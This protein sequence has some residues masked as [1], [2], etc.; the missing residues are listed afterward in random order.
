MEKS[1]KSQY[2]KR[3]LAMAMS[4]V[5]AFSVIFIFD[6]PLVTEAASAE[7]NDSMAWEV[8]TIVNQE[9]AAQGL[10]PLTMDQ[11]LVNSA[12]VRSAEIVQKFD[13]TR[14]DGFSCFTAFPSGQGYMGENIAAGQRSASAV[15][16]GWMNSTGHRA[17][18]LSSNFKSIGI[19]CYYVPGSDYGYYWVQCFGDRV[20]T[21]ASNNSTTTTTTTTTTSTG[22]STVYNGVD[23]SSVYNYNYY[24]NKYADLKA[25]FGSNQAAAL[26]HF[27]NSGMSEGRQGNADFNVDIYK[28]NYPD[29][30]NAF[31]NDLQKYYLHYINNGKKEGRNAKTLINK[32]T[33]T[34]TA[35]TTP[36]TGIT[37]YNGVDYSPV[38]NYSYYINKY[39]DL[40]AAFGSNQTAALAHFVN[41]GMNEGRQGCQN[42]NVDVYKANYPDLQNAFGS[43]LKNYYLHYINNG[44]GEGRNAKTLINKNT[45][46]T[47]TTSTGSTV[48]NGVDYSAVF[49]AN[50]YLNKYADLHA[51]FGNNQDAALAHFVNNGMNEGRQ[52]KATFN[53]NNYKNRYADLRAAFGNDLKS[54][55]IHY[56]N[57]GQ[58]ENRN[59][60]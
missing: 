6:K 18:I 41:N 22:S 2:L 1:I 37:V 7:Y 15:M 49:D 21:A 32:T 31:G 28:S 14:P 55:Y 13:H 46:T 16:N 56:I 12:K 8:L 48:Y 50:Y 27:V 35:T 25:A 17:N 34:T 58:R 26:A 19:A 60:Q 20:T 44:K 47:T 3:I 42:F 43:N 11:G 45:A 10:S 33:T 9:R 24:I 38:Y 30:Q 57:N 59:G 40:K 52:A 36:S 29:L 54:Y 23:Y 4:L 39:A 53:V 5:L 51:A